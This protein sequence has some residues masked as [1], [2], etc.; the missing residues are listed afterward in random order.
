MNEL[1]VPIIVTG[2]ITTLVALSFQL[3]LRA[4]GGIIDFAVG[5]YVVLAGMGSAFLG[6]QAGLPFLVVNLCGALFAVTAAFLSESGAIGPL[7]RLSRDTGAFS[8]VL[9]TVAL[10]WV[11]EQ[12]ARLVFGDRPLRGDQFLSDV[13]LVL[14]NIRLSAH[15][16]IIIVVAMLIVLITHV[17]LEY[18]KSGRLLR[19]V[20]DNRHASEILGLGIHRARLL[21][22]LVAGVIAGL[23]GILAG[24]LAGLQPITGVAFLANGFVAL[25]LG[26]ASKTLGAAV[27]GLL[28]AAINILVSRYFG[29]AWKDYS[30]LLL[31]LVIFIARPQG[32]VAPIKKRP[33]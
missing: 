7:S 32:I 19:A 15:Q 3:I 13:R 24:P 11:W 23:A 28:L 31:A 12:V 9:G 1:I 14:G 21:G 17:W 16:L 25:F 8:P 30:V 5:Q 33:S 27:G 6:G 4:T 18:S 22:F 26:G 20:G 2:S 29:M 10:L